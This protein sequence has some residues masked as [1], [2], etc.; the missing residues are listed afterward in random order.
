[1]RDAPAGGPGCARCCKQHLPDRGCRHTE[2]P[3]VLLQRLHHILAVV[4]PAGHQAAIP[5]TGMR[6]NTKRLGSLKSGACHRN[7]NPSVR[8]ISEIKANWYV[9]K[10]R[11]C[12]RDMSHCV[13]AAGCRASSCAPFTT[14]SVEELVSPV[15][16]Y[17]QLPIANQID[18]PSADKV[19]GFRV[20]INPKPLNI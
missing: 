16:G 18:R 4:C 9:G 7:T 12:A 13:V 11:R 5:S 8:H 14:S 19:A 6:H 3:A 15:F 10:S 1:M 20:S 17:L 2:G